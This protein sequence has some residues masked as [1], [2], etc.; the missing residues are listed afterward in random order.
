MPVLVQ[1]VADHFHATRQTH[2]ARRTFTLPGAFTIAE[3]QESSEQGSRTPSL[4]SL[5][6]PVSRSHED[7]ASLS[8]GP[9][10][11]SGSDF[12]ARRS[13]QSKSHTS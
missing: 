5:S 7:V 12:L 4:A 2:S 10:Q 1:S 3:E 6:R 13:S 11:K 8:N 9:V